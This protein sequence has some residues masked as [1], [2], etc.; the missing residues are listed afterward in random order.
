MPRDDDAAEHKGQLPPFTPPKFN[1]NQDNL[2][3]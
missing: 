3:K 1:W 2:Y